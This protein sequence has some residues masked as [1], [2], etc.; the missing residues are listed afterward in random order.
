MNTYDID[1]AVKL[2]RDDPL[3][4]PAARYLAEFRDL[5]NENSDGWAYWSY[6]TKCADE[7]CKLISAAVTAKYGHTWGYV[8]PTAA[9]VRK[10]M[11]RI[12]R[13]VKTNKYLK[14]KGVQPPVLP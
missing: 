12:Q 9:D 1:E 14:P 11:M 2:L 3:L 6:G 10:A 4:G 8:R 5:I 13:S 7:L